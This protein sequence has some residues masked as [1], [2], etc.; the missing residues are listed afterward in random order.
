[1][2]ATPKIV[3]AWSKSV[4]PDQWRTYEAAI[5]ALE[6]ADV[7]FMLGGAFAL[8]CY[9]GRWRNTK[10]L[11][12]YIQPK[13]RERAIAA[14]VSAGFKD[15]FTEL[16]YDRRW[17]CRSTRETFI[18]D[19][20]WAMANQRAEVLP[21][22]FDH[23]PSVVLQGRSLAVM[24]AEE[25][26]WCK[27]YVLQR[28]RCDWP[29]LLNLLYACGPALDWPRLLAR[30]GPDAA[31]LSAL[32][33]VFKWV[34]PDRAADLPP[35]VEAVLGSVETKAQSCGNPVALLDSRPWFAG[36]G[37]EDKPLSQ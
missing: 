17:I 36:H 1:M 7:A 22:W 29:D 19:I 37:A 2:T 3:T 8:A 13:D 6:S 20:I 16:P 4:P 18:V 27:L 23:A 25:F 26:L 34:S 33:A 28:D 11:D 35:K 9:T 15:Y 24:P 31:L 30:L 14:L 10:D 21:D 32:V 5:R 12:L